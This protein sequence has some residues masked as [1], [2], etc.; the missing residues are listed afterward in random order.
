MS[1]GE[2][3]KYVDIIEYTKLGMTEEVKRLADKG[4]NVNEMNKYGS[5]S[6]LIAAE[7]NDLETIHV[8]TKAGADLKRSNC[9]GVT[10]LDYAKQNKDKGT[11]KFIIE[12][13][14]K[15]N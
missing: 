11:I 14:N 10:P 7:R 13:M 2:Y 12:N 1:A 3:R 6:I 5:T 4:V 15:K 9:Y 8:L